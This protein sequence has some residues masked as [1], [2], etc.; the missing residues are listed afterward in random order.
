[1]NALCKLVGGGTNPT[2]DA[3]MIWLTVNINNKSIDQSF[4][5]YHRDLNYKI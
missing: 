3:I 1:M 4:Y 5:S 2:K